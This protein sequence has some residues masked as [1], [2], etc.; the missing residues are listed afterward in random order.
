MATYPFLS[1]DWVTEARKLRE[2][3]EGRGSAIAHQVTMNLVITDVPFGTGSI[4]AHLDTSDG[5][6]KLELGHVDPADLKITVDYATAKAILIEEN[7]QAAMQAFMSGKIK[8]EGDMA[9]LMALQMVPPDENAKEL[10]ARLRAM[11]A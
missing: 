9:K 7:S 6:I 4:D 5:G 10:A 8:V 2:E 11:T 1:D 3:Y